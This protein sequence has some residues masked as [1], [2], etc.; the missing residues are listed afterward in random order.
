[1]SNLVRRSIASVG[2]N[3]AAS[4]VQILVGFVRS[5][6]LARFLAVET[7]GIYAF[8]SSIVTLSAIAP[9]FGMGGA[10][11]HR[12]EETEDED[13]TAAVHLTL[14]LMFTTA[15]LVL[16]SIGTLVF[17]RGQAR[18]ALL[19]LT[20][21]HGGVLLCQTP[22]LILVRRVVHRRLALLQSVNIVLSALTAVLLAWRGIELWALLSTD[23]VTL[24]LSV[25]MLYIWRPVW[26]PHLA[27][28]PPAMRYFLGY[29]SRNVLAQGLLR[30]L[31]R[32]DDMWTGIY[33][34]N[35][36][37]GYY[38]RAYSF[39]TYPRMILAQSVSKVA[40][41][42]YAE[43][44]DKPK[45]LSQAFFRTNAFL[46]RSGFYLAGILVLVAPEFIRILLGTKWLPMLVPFRFM[47]A[48]TMFDPI[49]TTVANLFLAV[50]KPGIVVRARAIQLATMSIGLFTLG[51]HWGI[52][53][54]ALAVDVMLVL[55]IGI[56]LYQARKYVDYSV[57]TLFLAPGI[58][59][60]LSMLMARLAIELPGV[61]GSPWR[62]GPLKA[63]VFTILYGAVLFLFERA[64][65]LKMVR[66]V[67]TRVL[68]ESG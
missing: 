43:V 7:F 34:G 46:V 53:G 1:M 68:R 40:G 13:R 66:F 4:I 26:R 38:S 28:S 37:M 63:I 17:A 30:A 8:A 32:V 39:A 35:T 12:S 31:D 16:L 47:L 6:L 24:V 48:F 14:K 51:P 64:Q 49:K 59:V 36:A 67:T 25:I 45:R 15:W 55:G 23:I 19:V 65:L 62:T 42:T 11:V 58:A 60:G 54:V 61:L 44:A 22:S 2:W 33:L 50:G 3:V 5:L 27:W 57:K 52:A 29:G 41:G 18:L 56:L 9:S 20:V 10:F 21:S